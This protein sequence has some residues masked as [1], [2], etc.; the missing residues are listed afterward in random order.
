MQ[1]ARRLAGAGTNQDPSFQERARKLAAENSDINDED[2]TKCRTISLY[3]VPF[4][5]HLEKVYSNLRPQ[6]KR[7]PEDKMED[8]DVNSLIW[9]M[10]VIVTQQTAV[11]LGKDCLDNLHTTKKQPQRTVK[12]VFDA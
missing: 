6:L 2:D 7:K 11:H 4:V 8:L 1:C 12:Q 3:L 10:F 5:P 9:G